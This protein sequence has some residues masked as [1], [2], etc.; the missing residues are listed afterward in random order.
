MTW[1]SIVYQFLVLWG[2]VVGVLSVILHSRVNWRATQMGRHLMFYMGII[3]AVLAFT[4]L[5]LIF[6]WRD[7]W[8]SLVYVI[9]FAFVPIA[10]T[11]RLWLQWKA[12]RCPPDNT[13]PHGQPQVKSLP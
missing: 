4:L 11:Q 9:I 13:P 7:P 8:V 5:R 12:Q 1:L 3:A 6:G 2:A 10:M